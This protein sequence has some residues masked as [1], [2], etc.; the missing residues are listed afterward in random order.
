MGMLRPQRV[1][2]LGFQLW[3]S[4]PFSGWRYVKGEYLFREKYV[5]GCQF[6]PEGTPGG[7]GRGY[8]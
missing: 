4:G 7:N 6:F 1:Y 3:E 5:K 2:L 8:S